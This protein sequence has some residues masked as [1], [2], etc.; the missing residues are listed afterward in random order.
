MASKPVSTTP[1]AK[2]SRNAQ[3]AKATTPMHGAVNHTYGEATA[4]SMVNKLIK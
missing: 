2:Q 3:P 1:P 4:K